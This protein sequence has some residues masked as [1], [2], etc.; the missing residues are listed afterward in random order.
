MRP[1]REVI[2]ALGAFA[3]VVLG[4]AVFNADGAFFAPA[5]HADALWVIS[6]FGILACGMTVVIVT[7]GI[8]LAVGSVVALTGVVFAK[9]VMHHGFGGWVAIPAAIGSGVLA[10]LVS[11]AFIAAL[12]LQPF[13]ATLAMMA[14]AR[15]LAKLGAEGKVI[16]RYPSP[17]LVESLNGG[18]RVLGFELR[19]SVMIFAACIAATLV[20]LRCL[21]I[22]RYAYAVGDN[23]EAARLSGVP[24]TLTKLVAYGYCGLL[25]GLAGVLFAA[26]VRQGNPD[27]GVGYE[28]TAIAMVVVGGTPLSGGRGGV[29]LT[30]LGALTVGYLRKVLDINAV[31]TSVQLM[32][33]GIILVLAVVAQGLRR[34]A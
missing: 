16:T 32:I 30:V 17:P 15:G 1:S 20:L 3:L 27:E 21:R 4:G 19:S 9:L 28:L 7:G 8:D 10:G 25:A 23:E 18:V 2:L 34:R 22:G 6:G 29:V 33:T 26:A 12:R 13:V 31:E 11:G 24:V 14:L 5:T